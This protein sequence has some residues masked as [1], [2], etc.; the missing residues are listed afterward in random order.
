MSHPTCYVKSA[1]PFRSADF[2]TPPSNLEGKNHFLQQACFII[3]AGGLK[4]LRGL[5]VDSI[6]STTACSSPA[7]GLGTVHFSVN[8]LYA[9]SPDEGGLPLKFFA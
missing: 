5:Q 9:P 8:L 1:F 4:M 7:R 3:L 6:P 2:L